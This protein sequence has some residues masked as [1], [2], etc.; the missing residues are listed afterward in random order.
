MLLF[1]NRLRPGLEHSESQLFFSMKLK[2]VNIVHAVTNS[3]S[4][5]VF[6]N[7]DIFNDFAYF[8]IIPGIS[9]PVSAR[10]KIFSYCSDREL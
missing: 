3:F 9:F 5:I 2:Y 1:V 7:G 10:L 8:I 6:C 4:Q